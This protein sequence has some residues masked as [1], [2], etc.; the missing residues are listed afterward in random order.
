[1]LLVFAAVADARGQSAS[2]IVGALR[3]ESG[4]ALAGATVEVASPALIEGQKVVFTSADG[5]YQ[6]VDLRP[7]EYTV[8]FSLS[9]FQTVRR[10]HIVLSASFTATVDVTL[11]VAASSRSS[12]CRAAPPRSTFGPARRSGP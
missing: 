10:E 11:P 3:D 1:M 4:G 8:T 9:G 5:R 7:G 12:P 2:A 6:V